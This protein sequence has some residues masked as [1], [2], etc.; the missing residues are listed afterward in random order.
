MRW[1]GHIAHVN[2]MKNGYE[3]FSRNNIEGAFRCRWVDNI[4]TY[5]K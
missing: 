1:A 4:K 3:H 5:F 2:E